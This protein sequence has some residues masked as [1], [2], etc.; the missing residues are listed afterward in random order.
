MMP[1]S[2][3]FDS[4]ETSLR[5]Q[6]AP[7]ETIHLAGTPDFPLAFNV[8]LPLPA[9]PANGNAGIRFEGM[10]IS[11]VEN[12]HVDGSR[13]GSSSGSTSVCIAWDK[14]SVSGAYVV[15]GKASPRITMDTGGS[16]L[17]YGDEDILPGGATGV[18]PIDDG[19]KAAMLDRA[20]AQ[21]TRLMDDPNGQALM[22]RYNEHN[23]VYNTVFVT[24]PA[25]RT[26]WAAEGA[27]K[28][29]ALH[30]HDA[31]GTSA[32]PT[33]VNPPP[34]VATFGPQKKSYNGNAFDQ[35]LQ[36]IVNTV[37]ADPGFNP[38]DPS[39]VPDPDS[40]FTKASL[41][42]MTFGAAVGQTGNTKDTVTPLTGDQVYASVNTAEKPAEAT[43][44]ELAN[45]LQQGT[46]PGGAAAAI[47]QAN[48]WR[49]LDEDDR[50]QVRRH[51]FA[52][53]KERA[54]RE[55]VKIETVWTGACDA[56]FSGASAE[57][58]FGVEDGR[59]S[60]TSV[61]VTLPA[62]EFEL[63]DSAWDGPAAAIVRER[64]AEVGFIRSLLRERIETALRDRIQAAARMLGG[65]A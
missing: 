35:Q 47:A 53:M 41:A 50:R 37:A 61:T 51:L 58:G 14:L 15:T 45:L 24:S 25:A 57:V 33:P 34:D 52:H 28:D 31:L 1:P 64:L 39:A 42:A 55:T 63:D 46:Q 5:R 8:D 21:R 2:A 7:G 54:E 48:N 38:F 3:D 13:S 11:G 6:F 44:N 27:T 36:V 43:V 18:T 23:E 62:F 29:M 56:E 22:S 26:A 17:D 9:G 32:A 60:C 49:V 16:M 10:Q 20:R 59:L 4:I 65:N 19:T 40:K 30:T 12:F